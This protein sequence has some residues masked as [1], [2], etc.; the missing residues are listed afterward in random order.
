MDVGSRRFVARN[1]Y[2]NTINGFT[3]VDWHWQDA[4]GRQLRA[5]FVLPVYRKP[6]TRTELLDNDAEFDEQDIEVK[7]WGLHY[8]AR[9]SWG[10]HGELFYFG[11][12]EEDSPG[13]PT[14][15]RELSTLGFSVYRQPQLSRFD[16]QVEAR[17]RW[18]LRPNNVR[19]AG[20]AHLFA[21]E[22]MDNAPNSNGQGDATY[23]NSQIT[24]SF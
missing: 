23:F 21:G 22:F 24:L 16:Y 11:L 18:H 4:G 9:L 2:R 14:R 12:D 3:G 13:R 8:A 17:V 10:D 6:N 7:F 20:I 5:F 19:R 1:R 15:N